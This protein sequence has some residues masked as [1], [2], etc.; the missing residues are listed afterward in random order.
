MT[1]EV[2]E[3]SAH[4]HPKQENQPKFGPLIKAAQAKGAVIVHTTSATRRTSLKQQLNWGG[5]RNKPRRE[6][7]KR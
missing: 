6:A 7:M 2:K 4:K 5:E 1:G 3:R